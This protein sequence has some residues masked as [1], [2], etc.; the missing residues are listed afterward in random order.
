MTSKLSPL[1]LEKAL[2]R[3]LGL[4][5]SRVK[6]TIYSEEPRGLIASFE[7]QLATGNEVALRAGGAGGE[8]F[9]FRLSG[10]AGSRFVLESRMLR[11]ACVVA[12]PEDEADALRFYLGVTTVLQ[13]DVLQ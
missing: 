4:I 12:T 6:I 1:T 13:V 5:G 3:L 8:A 11:R 7:G 9:V 10:E 2:R